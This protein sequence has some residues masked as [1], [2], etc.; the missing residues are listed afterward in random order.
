MPW[1]SRQFTPPIATPPAP[2]DKPKGIDQGDDFKEESNWGAIK[3]VVPR[4][5]GGIPQQRDFWGRTNWP[6]GDR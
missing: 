4:V 2:G 3:R 1:Q 6:K 5:I